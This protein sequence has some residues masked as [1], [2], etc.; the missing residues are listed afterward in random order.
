MRADVLSRRRRSMTVA[1]TDVQ[2]HPWNT[3]FEWQDRSGPY[4]FLTAE[5]VAQFD[6]D[7]FVVVEGV[8]DARTVEEITA[9]LDRFEAKVDAFLQGQKDG[10]MAI[11]ETGAITFTAPLLKRSELP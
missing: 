5:Q 10:R 1:G 3:G 4:R 8:F 7:G 2:L 11:A 9:E 6:R